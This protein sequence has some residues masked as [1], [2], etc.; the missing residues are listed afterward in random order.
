MRNII[1]R[2]TTVQQRETAKY[3]F[4]N[5]TQMVMERDKQLVGSTEHRTEHNRTQQNRTEQNT[6]SYGPIEPEV[7]I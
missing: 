3:Q 1:Q 7:Y 5:T 2:D 4:E 6:D